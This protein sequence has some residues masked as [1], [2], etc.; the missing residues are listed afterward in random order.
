MLLCIWS[1]RLFCMSYIPHTIL[2]ET[3]KRYFIKVLSWECDS[4][5]LRW[6]LDFVY[7]SWPSLSQTGTMSIVVSHHMTAE[8]ETR[9]S[10]WTVSSG[11][12]KRQRSSG[13]DVTLFRYTTLTYLVELSNIT[14][15]RVARSLCVTAS[16]DDVCLVAW[17]SGR[18]SV[19][20]T[21]LTLPT[22]YSV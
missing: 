3:H 14:V 2:G 5:P 16:L 15:C 4:P 21:H 11:N 8:T 13:D 18:A 19:S 9:V 12:C 7:S 6:T 1:P 22:I 20:Y 17:S 10:Q